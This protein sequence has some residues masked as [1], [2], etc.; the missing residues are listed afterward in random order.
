MSYETG[1]PI[2]WEFFSFSF[3]LSFPFFL[4]GLPVKREPSSSL[5]ISPEERCFSVTRI[6]D[7]GG[8]R[9]LWV[10]SE[11]TLFVCPT[12]PPQGR[13]SWPL[14]ASTVSTDWG[15]SGKNG[16]ARS[17]CTCVCVCVCVC[18]LWG[19]WRCLKEI[20]PLIDAWRAAKKNAHSGMQQS[21]ASCV[22]P[23]CDWERLK[24]FLPRVR[25][26][27]DEGERRWSWQ[28]AGFPA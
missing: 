2:L 28:A 19:R 1:K 5:R 9:V 20:G 8:G 25:R 3:F 23:A 7:V 26:G 22:A 15:H 4:E 18:V 12:R 10:K 24:A 6:A 17:L 13:H 21:A 27:W 16:L 11:E 14:S